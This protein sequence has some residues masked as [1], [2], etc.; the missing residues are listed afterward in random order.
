M[1][2]DLSDFQKLIT[3]SLDCKKLKNESHFAISAP[4][5]F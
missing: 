4:D 1:R 5:T 3:V 2:K